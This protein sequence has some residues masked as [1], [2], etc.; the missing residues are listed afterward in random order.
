MGPHCRTVRVKCINNGA[1]YEGYVYKF[2][3][4]LEVAWISGSRFASDASDAFRLL[5]AQPPAHFI[6]S[7]FSFQLTQ[8]RSV[9]PQCIPPPPHTLTHDLT[10]IDSKT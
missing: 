9:V 4:R 8:Q 1:G 6:T 5:S 10:G 3:F 2:D 7:I